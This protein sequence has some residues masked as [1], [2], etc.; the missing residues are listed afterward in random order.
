MEGSW[1]RFSKKSWNKVQNDLFSPASLCKTLIGPQDLLECVGFTLMPICGSFLLERINRFQIDSLALWG[2][3]V[4]ILIGWQLKPRPMTMNMH[5]GLKCCMY[6]CRIADGLDFQGFST[7]KAFKI[8][9]LGV[10]W[11]D[12]KWNILILKN[13][14]KMQQF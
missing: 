13:S 10:F 2:K 4:N 3:S 14:W 6:D 9:F 8:A 1:K 12:R 11:K 7:Q 5:R